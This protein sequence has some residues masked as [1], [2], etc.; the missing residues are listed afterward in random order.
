MAAFVQTVQREDGPAVAH[1]RPT[2]NSALR[3]NGYIALT[4]PMF[5][6]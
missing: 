4:P 5:G 6:V 2:I 1:S 3:G